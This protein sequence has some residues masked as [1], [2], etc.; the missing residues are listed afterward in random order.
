MCPFG[1]RLPQQQSTF[2]LADPSFPVTRMAFPLFDVSTPAG[3]RFLRRRNE[4]KKKKEKIEKKEKRNVREPGETG[5][6]RHC[7]TMVQLSTF[8]ATTGENVPVLRRW[9]LELFVFHRW[10]HEASRIRGRCFYDTNISLEE[11]V[12]NFGKDFW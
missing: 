5:R 12:F 7:S 3:T 8:P 9:H 11:T 4:R 6:G 1:P 2:R 10:S